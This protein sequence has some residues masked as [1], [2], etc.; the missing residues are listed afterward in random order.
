MKTLIL[1]REY[2]PHVYGGAG[3]H[4]EHLAAELAKLIDVEV[5]C[6]G[7]QSAPGAS[8]K[9][10]VRGFAPWR[11][12]FGALDLRL[13][14]ALEPLSVDLAMVGA[15][16]DADL[17]HCHTWYA[18]MAGV[19][20]QILYGLPFV[21]TLHSLEP[22]RPWKEDQ[23]G[24]GYHLSRWIERTAVE[25]AD[26]VIAVSEGSRREILA[27]YRVDPERVRVIHNGIDTQVF[28][29]VDPSE[30]LRKYAI[31]AGRPYLLFV[32]RIAAQKGV[33]HLVRAIRRVDPALHAV[34]CAGEPDTAEIAREM[35]REARSLQSER[36]GIHWIQEMVPIS[37]LVRL[38][39]GATVFVCP[40]IYEPFGI[41]NLEAMACGCPVVAS[42]VGGIPEA[43]AD[44][45]TGILVP[46]ENRGGTDFEP[47]DPE[48]FSCDLAE[49]VNRV[50]RDERARRAMGE[51]GRRRVEER[52]SWA[53]VAQKTVDLYAELVHAPAPAR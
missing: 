53:S 25:A 46:F 51:A 42:R 11:E 12:A 16:T 47:K 27:C 39:S 45:E 17:V 6:F 26:R 15:P 37:D 43:V 19:W 29:K 49:A 24:R 7:S 1:T 10:E 28:R 41:V 13:R 31:P 23:L 3:V 22:L 30:A 2:P 5:R 14:K 18:D 4:V 32:G 8:G 38:Y 52:F 9:P 36:P 48:R 50:F 40:S 35:E 44:G 20:M 34:L 21:V 33:L